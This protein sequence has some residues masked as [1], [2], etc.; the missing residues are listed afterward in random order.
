MPSVRVPQT[1]SM[2]Y[3]I[4]SVL[5]VV[6]GVPTKELDPTCT[7]PEKAIINSGPCPLGFESFDFSESSFD[8][9]HAVQQS[10]RS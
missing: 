4:E 10:V 7:F 2:Y 5:V 1:V 9:R 3:S 6:C 8:K